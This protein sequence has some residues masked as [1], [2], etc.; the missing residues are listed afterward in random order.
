MTNNVKQPKKLTI[1]AGGLIVVFLIILLI[2]WPSLLKE[3]RFLQQ[4]AKAIH[5][6]HLM[7]KFE[8]IIS[9]SEEPHK[10]MGGG[11][12]DYINYYQSVSDQFPKYFDTHHIIAYCQFYRGDRASSYQHYLFLQRQ[13]IAFFP[14]LY[15]L[16]VHEYFMKNYQQS[17]NYLERAVKLSVEDYMKYFSRSTVF[18]QLASASN[19]NKDMGLTLKSDYAQ[20]YFLLA[21]ISFEEGKYPK[22]ISEVFKAAQLGIQDKRLFYI[23]GLASIR[24][25][26]AKQ[27]ATFMEKVIQL[28]DTYSPAYEL[29]AESLLQLGENSE[30]T[31]KLL[32]RAEFL[33]T[34]ATRQDP[35]NM[36]NLLL[37]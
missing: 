13:N 22:V 4:K 32:S 36:V 2:S 21:L 12:I 16:A 14:Y 28:D 8:P 7:P 24:M 34:H 30:L 1:A 29:L 18:Q 35:W 17:I 33:S 26:N 25:N 23:A 20:A 27:A 37:Y 15:N 6:N 31:E 19:F 3:R 5:L 11:L 10:I 9:F